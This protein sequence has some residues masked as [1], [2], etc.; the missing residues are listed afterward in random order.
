MVKINKYNYDFLGVEFES[1]EQIERFY[2]L[3]FSICKYY[4]EEKLFEIKKY[5]L[6]KDGR[7]IYDKDNNYIELYPYIYFVNFYFNAND[8]INKNKPR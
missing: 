6:S 4:T 1:Q 7:V 2:N 3:R 5:K 8:Y